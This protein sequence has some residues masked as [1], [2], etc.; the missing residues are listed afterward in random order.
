MILAIIQARM[1]SKRLPGKVMKPIIGR[2]ILSLEIER[3]SR[4]TT[5]D[6][7]VVATSD[8]AEDD[9]IEDL[10]HSIDCD[11]Y[12]GSLNNVLDRYYQTAMKYSADHVVRLTGDCPLIDPKLVD[13]LIN[14][15]IN[16][17]F[18]YACNSHPPTLPDGLDAEIISFDTLR[19]TWKNAQGPYEL[20]HVTPYIIRHPDKF[21][22]AN[23]EYPIDLSQHRWTVDEKEDF[24]LVRLIFEALYP[25]MPEF[26]MS[27]VL[28]YIDKRP[29]LKSINDQYKR[30]EGVEISKN[31]EKQFLS[32]QADTI[33]FK[34]KH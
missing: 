26:S 23:W 22:I 21:R 10:C 30:N 1:S 24:E 18:D 31:A 34:D 16:E 15:Y 28:N 32:D 25:K 4:C 6:Q 27:D 12:R 5:I 14:Y 33:L 17:D 2:P 29:E 8:R 13:D 9:P 11:I 7:I 3:L 19:D 20:E